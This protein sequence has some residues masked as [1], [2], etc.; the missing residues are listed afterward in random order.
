MRSKRALLFMSVAAA[1][2]TAF[3][4][5]AVVDSMER[6]AD[7]LNLFGPPEV[8]KSTTSGG[9]RSPYLVKW[10]IYWPEGVRF[11]FLPEAPLG[12]S[13]PNV[14]WKL[15]GILDERLQTGLTHE[16]ALERLAD[17]VWQQKHG[18]YED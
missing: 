11:V 8:V 5:H 13:P 17:R 9:S 18:S 3:P 7:V 12:A 14:L 6:Q 4:V 1:M 10:F 15:M 16:Q 2:I